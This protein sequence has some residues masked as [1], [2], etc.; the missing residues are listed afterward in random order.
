MKRLGV[1]VLLLL[2][3]AVAAFV[4]GGPDEEGP[5]PLKP[6]EVELWAGSY[7]DVSRVTY[8]TNRQVVM[9][10]RKEDDKGLWYLGKVE[11]VDPKE[12]PEPEQADA[13]A[14]AGASP[15]KPKPVEPATF[16]AVSVA[17]KIVKALAP[18]RAARHI[19][20][21]GADREKVFGLDKPE[22]TLTVE[23]GQKKHVLIIGGP[24]PGAGSRY[25]RDAETKLVYVIDAQPV[26][27]LEGGAAR[28]SERS[29][30]EWKFAE[31]QR[32]NVIAGDKSRTFIK[33]GTEG[34]E[35]WAA[36]DKPDVNDETANNWLRKIQNLRPVKFLDKL[37][38]G[39][40][41]VVRVE[42]G[43]KNDTLGYMEV[44]RYMGEG[45]KDE[46][47][48]TSDYLRMP[49]TVAATIAEQVA[50]DLSSLYPAA[51]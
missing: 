48:V 4:K 46:F 33:S 16:A 18:L 31:V 47:V 12:E 5:G 50:D 24:T 14:D 15:H 44:H 19:G 45:D 43:S 40:E 34:R 10:E 38:E 30:H 7:K 13:G 2:V 29:M 39:A 8:E 1:H 41:K 17:D 11:P 21:I 9:L 28:L 3:A 37:P 42:Y 6:G 49:A 27:D 22:G 32:A 36:S 20:E 23:L 26:R 51:E 35:F 25:V